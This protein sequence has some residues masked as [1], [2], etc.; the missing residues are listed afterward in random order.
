METNPTKTTTHVQLEKQTTQSQ[1]TEN[2]IFDQK[3]I[4]RM[5]TKQLREQTKLRKIPS[6]HKKKHFT[7]AQILNSIYS[8]DRNMKKQNTNTERPVYAE[9]N[10][11]KIPS[12][13]KTCNLRKIIPRT[14]PT[15]YQNNK[16]QQK[17][18]RFLLSTSPSSKSSTQFSA[19]CY[20]SNFFFSSIYSPPIKKEK[21]TNAKYQPKTTTHVQLEKQIK[22]SQTTEN[23]SFNQK[24]IER[25]TTKQL[26]EQA[27]LRKL[28]TSR[29]G[30]HFTTAQNLNS[31]Y[32]H[33]R[34]IKKKT[35]TEK[36]IYTETNSKKIPNTTKTC[37]LQK[38]IPH[39]TPT[40]YQNNK[41]QQNPPG[42]L[43]PT[44]PSSRSSTNF[45]AH[46]YLSN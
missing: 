15:C 19:N 17:P 41:L 35:I 24:Q 27:E 8:H 16:L 32:S 11:T 7:T 30:K 38:I 18:P 46:Y 6:S 40:C 13:T 28:S 23:L 31:I 29:K 42:F 44:S 22:Q 5:T 10:S 39:I 36:R 43:L 1:T 3:Q 25:M 9:T 37:N 33:D 20:L 34:N 21:K 26:R 45:S 4:E 12:T 14:T 2:L